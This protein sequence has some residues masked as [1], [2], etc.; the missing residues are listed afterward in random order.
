MNLAGFD[1]PKVCKKKI[2]CL[3]S[4]TLKVHSAKT[5]RPL[6]FSELG[7]QRVSKN[8]VYL[9]QEAC[10]KI[11]IFT[12]RYYLFCFDPQILMSNEKTDEKHVWFWNVIQSTCGFH[13]CFHWVSKLMHVTN[14]AI[15]YWLSNL[16]IIDE[17]ENFIWKYFF[18]IQP[19]F[20]ILK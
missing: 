18:P 10:S 8:S 7:K 1:R 2:L 6:R 19:L 11:I 20:E 16:W 5:S 4:P 13:L 15:F 12:L 9:T 17:F 14:L 3:Y